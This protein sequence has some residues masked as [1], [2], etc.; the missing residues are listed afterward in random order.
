MR[1]GS[2]L[3]DLH[4]YR[5]WVRFS[6]AFTECDISALKLA[7]PHVP[8]VLCLSH[9]R[10]VGFGGPGASLRAFLTGVG[11]TAAGAVLVLGAGAAM[12]LLVRRQL[13]LDTLVSPEIGPRQVIPRENS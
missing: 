2:G 5:G 7:P 9:P 1:A 4:L 6:N 13:D 12:G 8:F 3:F 11:V 10:T